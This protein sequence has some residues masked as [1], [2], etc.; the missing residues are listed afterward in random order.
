[1]SLTHHLTLNGKLPKVARPQHAAP[2]KGALR[3]E[4]PAR[5]EV[6]GWRGA[7]EHQLVEPPAVLAAGEI[8]H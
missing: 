3:L 2:S 1:M 5:E 7:V 6:G 8:H 4:R